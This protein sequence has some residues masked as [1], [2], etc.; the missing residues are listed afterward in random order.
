MQLEPQADCNMCI[1][2]FLNKWDGVYVCMECFYRLQVGIDSD[3]I[4]KEEEL[5]SSTPVDVIPDGAT[6]GK[7]SQLRGISIEFLWAFT[8]FYDCWKWNSWDVIKR[9]IKPAT[10]ALRCRYVELPDMISGGHMGP[11]A[12]FIS[13]AQAGTWGGANTLCSSSRSLYDT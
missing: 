11:A 3:R 12:T 9:V 5:E 1:H 4:A 10:E 7:M 6:E 2:R 8:I 13:Y